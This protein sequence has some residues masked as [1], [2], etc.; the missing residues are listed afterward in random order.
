MN[1]IPNDAATVILLRPCAD[2]GIKD[3]EVLLVLRNQKSRFVPGYHVFPGGGLDPEDY[4]SGIERFIR[5][6]D[7]KQ[8]A[9]ILTDM[10][11]PDKALG[12]WVAGIRETF[13]EVGVLIART[14]DGAPV[15]IGT[16]AERQ[17]Y[18]RYRQAINKGEMKF[19]QMLEAED[20]VLPGDGLHYFSHW[21]TPEI[22][23]LRYDVRFFVTEF[24]AAQSVA[25]DGE[26][27]TDHVWLRPSV[28]LADYEAGKLGM[29]LPQIMTLVELSRFHTAADVIASVKHRN[30]PAHLT[31]IEHIDGKNVEVMPD[32]T[33]FENRPP[34]Y[35]WPDETR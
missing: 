20:I 19:A 7:R 3:I 6:I 30:I 26:E 27:L 28:A 5:G 13:E 18:G 1:A 10:S 32:G 17:R 23:P 29:I 12:A 31:K 11:V 24:P 9:R 21:I 16:K 34:V 22:F 4:G 35:S 2:R 14:K 8:A 25:H 15:A 33:V